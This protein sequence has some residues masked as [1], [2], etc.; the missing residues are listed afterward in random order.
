MLY[1]YT[2][3]CVQQNNKSLNINTYHLNDELL[4]TK[5]KYILFIFIRI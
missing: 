4:K 5:Y 2:Y 3:K 1:N